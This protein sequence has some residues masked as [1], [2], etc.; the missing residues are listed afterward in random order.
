M[1]NDLPP[2]KATLL[3]RWQEIGVEAVLDRAGINFQE[4]FVNAVLAY[5]G[6]SDPYEG[7]EWSVFQFPRLV[8]GVVHAAP[9]AIS[10]G[11]KALWEEW[12][13]EDSHSHHNILRNHEHLDQEK[14]VRLDD[15]EHP[16][17]VLRTDWYYHDD[18][19]RRP[20]LLR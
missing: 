5:P 17:I 9:R 8:S 4:D 12:Y 1:T 18:L 6:Q 13:F 11:E 2:W 3:D 20:I 19:D 14:H 16:A 15:D 10:I 7:H